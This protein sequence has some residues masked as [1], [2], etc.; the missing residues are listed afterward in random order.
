MRHQGYPFYEERL[1]WQGT[2]GEQLTTLLSARTSFAKLTAGK[3]GGGFHANYCLEWK[4]A[5]GTTLAIICLECGE[6]K[7]YGP[8]SQLH[9]DLS[10]EAAQKIRPMLGRYRKN[11][12]AESPSP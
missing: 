3:Q 2:D 4:T 5:E 10:Q 11:C 12:P 9:C 7:M 8:K 1:S 6:V